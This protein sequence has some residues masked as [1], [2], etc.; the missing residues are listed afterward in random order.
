MIKWFKRKIIQLRISLCN[1]K[2]TA[3]TKKVYKL[4]KMR[5][6]AYDT[7]NRLILSIKHSHYEYGEKQNFERNRSSEIV[8]ID[9]RICA[10]QES[11]KTL[12]G[13]IDKERGKIAKMYKSL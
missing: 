6:S 12:F 1:R 3:I 9:Y 11:S 7:R 4:N 5:E 10:I 2:I 13:K 8:K